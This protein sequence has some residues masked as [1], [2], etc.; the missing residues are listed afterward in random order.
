MQRRTIPG[1]SGFI[2]SPWANFGKVDNKGVDM[3][4][5]FNRQFSEDFFL[6]LRGTFTYAKNTI[7][8]QDEPSAIIGTTRSST[9]KSVGQ[10]F[11]M[12]AHGLFTEADFK[13]IENGVLN[14]DVP[15]HTL[16]PVR[17]GD[18]RYVDLN[19]DGII[20]ALDRTAIGGTEDPRVVFGFGLNLRYK[21][22]D[23]GTFFQGMG[24]TYRIIGG[25]NFIPGSA[26]G[27]MGNILTNVVDRWTVDNPRQDVFYPRLSDYQSANNNEASTWWL[28]D[29]SFIRMKNLEV[30]YN[31]PNRW[32]R[33][34][35]LERGRLFL[36]GS[37]LLTISDFKLWDPELG[38]NNG[39]RYPIMKSVSFGF[40]INL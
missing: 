29:M 6:N 32:V 38:V 31:L 30:G 16:G 34:M 7:I 3:S 22:F 11:G 19:N 18:I 23:F 33:S 8:E 15:R 2:N 12:V 17:P 27:S 26:N 1:F 21:N 37:N 25:A 4:L 39:L 10:L 5:D 13:D 35:H 36:R 40:E 9:G 28:R 24:Q 20:D 14:D